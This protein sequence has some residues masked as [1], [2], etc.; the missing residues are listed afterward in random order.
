MTL[1]ELQYLIALDQE[2]HFGRAAAACG[3]SQPAL[4]NAIHHLETELEVILF[5]RSR[6]GVRATTVGE[7]IID[8]ARRVLATAASIKDLVSAGDNHLNAPISVGAHNT[9][10]PY[11]FPRCTIQ[12]EKENSP[13][14]LRTEEGD[15]ALLVDR[16]ARGDLDAAIVT[17]KI[18]A[19]DI[20]IQHLFNEPLVAVVPQQ[21]RLARLPTLTASCLQH[22]F[23]RPPPY[24]QGLPQRIREVLSII[25]VLPTIKD[26]LDTCF[27]HANDT[28]KY[29]LEMVRAML[30][31][32]PGITIMPLAAALI[33]CAESDH[34]VFRPFADQA[35]NRPVALA[36]R[37]S[38][39]RHRAIDALR[40]VILACK[41][42]LETYT[43]EHR[44]NRRGLLVDNTF[45]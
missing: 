10:G 17:Q 43:T 40:R 18:H 38:Y 39:P 30:S 32:G 42:T 22:E 11:L 15:T 13:L 23:L 37:T 26:E 19:A 2:Q 9:I 44:S 5:E 45:W 28:E 12:L 1:A 27:R 35:I 25:E 20:L 16:L 24:E 33:I 31:T 21:H 34:L 36:W 8:Q 3:V 7:Q 29:S 4:S 14:T 6:S 41:P